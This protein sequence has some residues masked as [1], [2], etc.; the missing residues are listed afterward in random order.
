MSATGAYTKDKRNS[1]WKYFFENG[2]IEAEEGYVYRDFAEIKEG[3]F[4]KYYESGQLQSAYTYVDDK[5]QGEYITY[6]NNGAIDQKGQYLNDLQDGNW[7]SFLQMAKLSAKR[8][9]S[10]AKELAL[11]PVRMKMEK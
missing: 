10:W 3:K 6:H 7:K 11:E 4:K 8:S 9:I 2:S 5:V 1:L